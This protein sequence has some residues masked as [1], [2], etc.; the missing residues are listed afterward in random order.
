MVVFQRM[1]ELD[2]DTLDGESLVERRVC[3]NDEKKKD[4]TTISGECNW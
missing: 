4:K 2:I 3:L 1:K